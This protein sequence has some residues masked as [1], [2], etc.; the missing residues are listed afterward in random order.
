MTLELIWQVYEE[1]STSCKHKLTQVF[2]G[3]GLNQNVG[4]F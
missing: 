4:I 2:C 1:V 3:G